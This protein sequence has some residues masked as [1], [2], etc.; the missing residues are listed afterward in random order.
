[1]SLGQTRYVEDV[2][3]LGSFPI[4]EGNIAAAIF[5]TTNDF[6]GV[7]R[8]ASDLQIDI[9]RVTGVSPTIS[10]E[11]N[12]LGQH[13]IIIGTIGK[14]QMIDRLTREGKINAASI[15]GKWESFLIQVVPNPLPGIES[16][17]VICG[18]DKRGT[19]YGIYD[20]SEQIGI[21]PWYFW[22]DV[23]PEHHEKLFAKA[24]TFVQG[25]PAVK[26]RGI[27]LNDEAPDLSNWIINQFGT[28]PIQTNPPIPSGVANYNRYFYTNVFELILRLKG[29]YLWPAMWNNAFNEDD[30]NNPVLADEYGIVMGNSHQEPM[31][32][33]QKEWDRRYLKT[34]GTW[35][36]AKYPD[37][38]ETFWHEGVA[39]NKNYENIITLGLRG[40]NDTPMAEGGTEA[41]R[42]LL[43][44]IVA[45]QRK[46]ISAEVNSNLTEVPQLWCL[47]KEVLDFYTPGCVCL[48][49]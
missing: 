40:A 24:G 31:L 41:N 18:S 13:T 2:S 3:S 27:F 37:V 10:R 43:E 11:E 21:S 46:I 36:Y 22:A 26:Y 4:V 28:I 1:L 38:L 33:A 35:N 29:N 9:H 34:L 39:R 42:A 7:M 30:T 48:T 47:Y 14:S 16:A 25:P 17:L 32:R 49:M 8:A 12:K 19:I 6:A 20:L 44:K 15:A 5:V 23:P 45:V